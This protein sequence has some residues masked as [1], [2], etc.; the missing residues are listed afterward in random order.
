MALVEKRREGLGWAET[1]EGLGQFEARA[2]FC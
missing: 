2:N 1:G